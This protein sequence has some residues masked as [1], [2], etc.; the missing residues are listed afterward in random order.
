MA[1]ETCQPQELHKLI[2]AINLLLFVFSGDAWVTR[3]PSR[4]VLFGIAHRSICFLRNPHCFS[5]W[6]RN[7]VHGTLSPFWTDLSVDSQATSIFLIWIPERFLKFRAWAFLSHEFLSFPSSPTAYIDERPTPQDPSPSLFTHL[8]LPCPLCPHS[9]RPRRQTEF[10]IRLILC[11]DTINI[12][13][14]LLLPLMSYCFIFITTM[15]WEIAKTSYILQG[16]DR[17][18][19]RTIRLYILI[20][21]L[22]LL[23]PDFQELN[24]DIMLKVSDKAGMN[25]WLQAQ[26]I[27]MGG[28]FRMGNTCIPVADSFWY[29]AKLIQLCKI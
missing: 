24:G 11:V 17:K 7:C 2:P 8:S 18:E 25:S 22:I 3:L 15:V 28:G 12:N 14:C 1:D 23:D 19:S 9:Q 27:G 21:L 6:E 13:I 26:T 29:L 5:G 20:S 10:H 16:N 4:A